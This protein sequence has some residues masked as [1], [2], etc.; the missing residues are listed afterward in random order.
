MKVRALKNCQDKKME[1]MMIL[2]VMK[3]DQASQK[4]RL[5]ISKNLEKM[6]RKPVSKTN[7]NK[8][9]SKLQ[10][11]SYKQKQTSVMNQKR[12]YLKWKKEWLQVVTS[13]KK[14]K[15]NRLKHKENC[16]WNLKKKKKSNVNCLKKKRDRM[17]SFSRKIS[18]IT[19][20]K[21]KLTIR[22]RSLKS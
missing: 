12:Y 7:N 6:N 5:T 1:L 9:L 3:T 18:T 19:I 17:L 16:N 8:R 15:E 14:R 11:N 13:S 10:I 2:N 4:I 22:K 20:Y 21:M